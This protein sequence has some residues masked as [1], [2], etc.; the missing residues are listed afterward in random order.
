MKWNQLIETII[1]A[2]IK[3]HSDFMI[4]L[5]LHVRAYLITKMFK[6]YSFWVVTLFIVYSIAKDDRHE[7]RMRDVIHYKI[8]DQMIGILYMPITV[9]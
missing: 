5:Y 8:D 9:G 4:Y 3:I 1:E 6:S 2:Q 7:I